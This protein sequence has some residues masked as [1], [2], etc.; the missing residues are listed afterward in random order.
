MNMAK[1]L[2]VA[3]SSSVLLAGCQ[4]LSY[5]SGIPFQDN[6]LAEDLRENVNSL[7][8]SSLRTLHR[9]ILTVGN[10]QLEMTGY[11]LIR[12]P[13]DIR[14]V[15]MSDFGSTLFEV[16]YNK[17]TGVSIVKN[18]IG[19]PRRW[20]TRAPMRDVSVIYLR[21]PSPEAALV[22]HRR[23]VI[24]LAEQLEDG[25]TEELLFD[26]DTH[27]LTG[28]VMSRNGRCLY[29]ASFSNNKIISGWPK[30][31]IPATIEIKDYR[32]NY[33]LIINVLKL[34]PG[35]FEDNLFN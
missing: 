21:S 26:A 22:R 14:L 18:N 6:A 31:A 8:P 3:M 17:K 16:V 24:A 13:A 12:R 19:L 30:S 35:K 33:Q 2:T 25:T 5:E 1:I 11:L 4:T 32:M 23:N 7:Y 27:C 10:I 20:L 9:G 28:Y 15:A 29:E 34:T